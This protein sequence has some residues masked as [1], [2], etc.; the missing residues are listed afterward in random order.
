MA[1]KRAP[2]Q[3]TTE[4]AN[5]STTSTE[6]TDTSTTAVAEPVTEPTPEQPQSFV[7]RLGERRSRIAIPDPFGIAS[8]F[9]AG[10]KLFESRQDRVMAIK[11]DERPNQE[12]IDR[13][14]NAG[15]RWNPNDK[16]WVHPVRFESARTTRI[17]A[18]RL[19][20]EVRQMVR[21]D[22]GIESSPDIPF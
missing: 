18:E 22:K 10:V 17:E 11:F 19:Y 5:N 9:A 20:Q 3:S 12:V 14:K 4:A 6:T 21:R 16:V 1:R 15:Y 7:E 13:V 8:D 2:D